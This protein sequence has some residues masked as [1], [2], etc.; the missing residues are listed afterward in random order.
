LAIVL[1]PAPGD[2][3]V[4]IVMTF[5]RIDAEAPFAFPGVTAATDAARARR[6]AFEGRKRFRAGFPPP[7]QAGLTRFPG[8]RM[9]FKS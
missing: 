4:G 2:P 9:L 1:N 8:E 7:R 5:R 3:A 6:G